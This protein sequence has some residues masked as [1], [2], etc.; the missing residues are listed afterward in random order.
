MLV[1]RV[2][3]EASEVLSSLR[4]TVHSSG[5]SGVGSGALLAFSNSAPLWMSNVA[6]PPSSTIWWGPTAS[7][8]GAARPGSDPWGG[9]VFEKSKA[10][11]V[12]HQYSSNDSPFQAKTG[13]PLG[14]SGVPLGPTARA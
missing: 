1:Q 13:M 10:R 6:S 8:L 9:E 11:S 7:R 2:R 4:T 12:H 14:L 3:E 5:S